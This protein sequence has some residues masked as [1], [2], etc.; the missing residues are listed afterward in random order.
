MSE[1]R[2]QRSQSVSNS[3][4]RQAQLSQ[5]FAEFDVDQSGHIEAAE[6]LALGRARRA[7]GHKSGEWTRE[8]NDRMIAKMAG[9]RTTQVSLLDFVSYFDR[10][11]PTDDAAFAATIVQFLDVAEAVREKKEAGTWVNEYANPPEDDVSPDESSSSDSDAMGLEDLAPRPSMPRERDNM[12][13]IE[14]N[15]Y[16]AAEHLEKANADLLSAK[17]AVQEWDIRAQRCH[18]EEL[19]AQRSEE[20]VTGDQSSDMTLNA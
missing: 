18:D 11:L 16:V 20:K 2:E 5:V 15:T 17:D 12:G 13:P 10:N 19:D 7:L 4:A 3:G 6:L 9:P 1:R 8:M 14:R